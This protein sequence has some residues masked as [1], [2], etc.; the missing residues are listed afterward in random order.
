MQQY[1]FMKTAVSARATPRGSEHAL[2]SR[3]VAAEK[4]LEADVSAALGRATDLFSR[5]TLMLVAGVVMAFI[6]VGVFYVSLP[7]FQPGDDR[8]TYLERGIRPTGML[9]F[10]EG[11][12]WFLLRQYRALIEDYK[13]FHR[14]YVK[15]VNYLVAL[16][17]LSVAEVT[18][19]QSFLVA[20]MISEDLTGR[21]KAGETTENLEGVKIIE[22]SPVFTLFQSPIQGIQ[23]K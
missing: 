14:M 2:R 6:G 17:I 9:I 15:R 12:A 4:F 19:H 21:L 16:K 3:D 20:S 23:K 7:Q 13:T 10:V 5:S 8:W 18:P 1:R 11:I 22:P